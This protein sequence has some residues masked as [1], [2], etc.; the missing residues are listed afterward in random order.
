MHVHRAQDEW[1]YVRSGEFL[2][3]VGEETFSL[4]PGDS[5]LGPRGVPR[6]F[7]AL[8]DTSALIV[9]FQPAGAIEQLFAAAHALSL[10]RK[11]GLSDWRDIVAP[12]DVE[13]VGPP[14]EIE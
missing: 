3:R 1:F 12:C 9:A 10:T 6:A 11:L 2:F 5:L 8:T 4:R 7:A 13:I 14:L